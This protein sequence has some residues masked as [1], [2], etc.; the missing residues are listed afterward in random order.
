M[1][2]FII[3]V[4][5]GLL[6][7]ATTTSAQNTKN[8]F[9]INHGP[10]LQEVTETG[11]TFVFNTSKPSFSYIELRK[12]GEEAGTDYYSAS[13]G[14]RQAYAEFHA[15]RAESLQPAT[16]YEYRIHA[17]EMRKFHPY[18]VIFGDS[19]MS[20]WYSFSTVNP[21]QE[22]GSIFITSD[23][24]SRPELLKRL[25]ELCDYQTCTAFFYAGDMMNY[26]EHGGEHPFT[27]FIDTSVEMF[28]TTIPFE[29][30]RGNH[31]TRG[32]LARQFPT[33]FPKSTG[34]LYGS[35]RLGD[36]MVIMLDSGEDKSD[37]HPVYAQLTDF[38][39]YRTEQAEWLKRLCA[40][41]EYKEARYHIV[42]SHFPMVMNEKSKQENMWYG[43]QD[44]INKFLPI[45]NEADVDLLVS[46]HTHQYEY[47]PAG[48]KDANFPV[49][50]QGF[51][52]AVRLDLKEGNIQCKVI[53]QDNEVLQESV[54]RVK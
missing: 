53:N 27:S 34:K 41:P 20:P 18:N 38:N 5:A 13:Y 46:G 47:Y 2:T 23:M 50:V 45:L 12:K 33:F 44:A 37:S 22:G 8:V 11:A 15:I 42:I 31:E 9:S 49:L 48:S 6:V 52:S 1:R 54:L 3:S 24:H 7:W 32:D 21:L 16:E 30:V 26:L 40:S 14:L 19:I 36:V 28:A 29:L 4:V 35:Y 17:K 10:Y 51:S 25:L 39:G 43:W